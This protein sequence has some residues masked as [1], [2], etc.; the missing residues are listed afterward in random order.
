MYQAWVGNAEAY[1]SLHRKLLEAD[2]W[3]YL[4]H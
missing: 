3:V 4:G 1:A 2:P